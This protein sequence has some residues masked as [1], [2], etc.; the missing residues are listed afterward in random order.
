MRYIKYA[1]VL[2]ILTG[3]FSCSSS[4]PFKLALLPDTQTYTKKFPQIANSQTEWLAANPDGFAFVLQQGD[5]T[6][7]NAPEQWEI[8]QAAFSKLDGVLPF[9]FVPG[10]H[11]IGNNSD[12]RNTDLMNKYLPYEKYSKTKTFGGVFE[13]GK[14][15]NTYHIFKAGG[16]NWLIISLEFGPRNE[17]L[18]WA[19]KIVEQHPRHKVIVN[20]HAYMY[21]NNKRMTDGDIWLP[22]SYGIG[23]DSLEKT[24]NNGEQIWQKFVS[25]HKNMLLVFSGH[26]LHSGVG[27][28]VSEGDNGNKVYQ[29]LANFQE[30]VEGTEM[31][32]NGFMR[33]LTIDTDKKTID[34]K[35]YSPYTDKYDTR[36]HQ[37][38]SFENV[39]F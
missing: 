39:T 7:W 20:T 4:K 28:L 5:I 25:K 14:M 38:F 34:V 6:D 24:V 35:T 27:T 37:Q 30:G 2:L 13:N 8:A 3:S 26:V 17:V 21:S 22:Q 18:D 33:I 36:S 10:N 32:G 9:T 15:D 16:L 31:G 29:M 1:I 12:V 11:D 19:N 23:K